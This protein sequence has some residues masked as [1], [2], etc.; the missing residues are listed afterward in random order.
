L[1]SGGAGRALWLLLLPFMLANL[2]YWTLPAVPDNGG[3][4]RVWAARAS[5][6]LL[7]MFGLALTVTLV[8]TGVQVAVDVVGW[9]CGADPRCVDQARVLGPLGSGIL[10][11]PGRRIV[12]TAVVPVLLIAAVGLLG[13]QTVRKTDP[14]PN[15]VV[16]RASE[17]PLADPR[18]WRGNP[19]MPVLRTTHVAAAASALAALVAWPAT[20]L[21]ATGAARVLGVALCLASVAVFVLCV[22][23]VAAERS[24]GREAAQT[25]RVLSAFGATWLRRAALVFLALA[26]IYSAWD[27]PDAWTFAARLPALREA[28]L[29][30]FCVTVLILLALLAT[31]AVQRP[32]AQSAA[33]GYRVAVRGLAAPT[34]AALAFLVAGGF[35][36]GFTFRIA[37]LFG[38]PVLSEDTRVAEIIEREITIADSSRSFDD[39][40]AAATSDAPLAIPPSFAWAGA[41][42]TVITLILIVIAVTTVVRVRRRVGRLAESVLAARPDE[43]AGRTA[44]DRDVRR[45]ARTEA[46]AALGDDVGRFVGRLVAASGVILLVGAAVYAAAQDN[47]RFVEEPPLS[48]ATRIG[49]WLMGVFTAA[50]IAVFWASYRNPTMRRTVGVLWDV[51]CFFPRAAHPLSPPS[52]G[53][54]AIPELADR[55]TALTASG[56]VLLSGH[57][58]GSILVAATVLQLPPSVADRVHLITHGSPL[59]RLYARFF[60]AY[61]GGTTLVAVR[62]AVG[63]RWRSLYRDT[64]P[65]GSW[66][67]DG[68][69]RP[70][71]EVDRFLVD[72]GKLTAPIRGH[73][74]YWGDDAYEPIVTD[75]LGSPGPE[76]PPPTR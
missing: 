56:R 1:T 61:L 33:P 23:L 63:G 30:C 13:R 57:S 19:G 60:P 72:P 11:G 9:Q 24:T 45:V 26:A 6:A 48:T 49:T 38:R 54:R 10:S 8:L 3:P 12:L 68:I 34:T 59:R 40:L 62:A 39:R 41:A 64:D 27:W 25:R 31:V 52:Y 75:L 2:A 16:T 35:S 7:R 67:L 17:E 14:T 4:G 70:V 69:A 18:F 50:T 29:G 37:E 43:A 21:V 36:A 32:W 46:I 15:A 44:A 65:I 47:W 53:E 58:Q 66:V 71:A 28:V 73:V 74:D 76:S 5:A 42:T 20:S 51:G 22:V 55:T